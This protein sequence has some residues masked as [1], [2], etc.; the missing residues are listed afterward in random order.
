MAT[1]E[2][3]QSKLGQTLEKRRAERA[4]AIAPVQEKIDQI[5]KLIKEGDT[6]QAYRI[7]EE[8]PI[9]DQLALQLTPVVGDA[10]AVFE[11]KE[12]GTRASERFEQDDTLG[13]IGN[14]ALSGLSGLSLLPIVGPV[15]D[16]AGKAAKG[17]TRVSRV[18]D[19]MP[20]GGS[21]LPVL[22]FENK[23]DIDYIFTRDPEL[24]NSQGLISRQREVLQTFDPNEQF[25][26]EK[27]LKRMKQKAG[28]EADG[29]LRGLNV[30]TDEGKPHPNLIDNYIPM[31]GI[32][33]K[34]ITP[35]ELDAYLQSQQ[36][37]LLKV[38]KVDEYDMVDTG[39]LPDE[40][41]RV[42][43]VRDS[44][45][46]PITD[47]IHYRSYGDDII[48][49][50]GVVK[51]GTG[52]DVARIQSDMEEGY[53]TIASKKRMR[54]Q[55]GSPFELME[56]I[57]VDP[58]EIK[59][60]TE[61]V[62]SLSDEY[63]DL[64]KEYNT[65]RNK[66]TNELL[67]ADAPSRLSQKQLSEYGKSVRADDVAGDRVDDKM[68]DKLNEIDGI[69]K[70][71][72][73]KTTG[74]TTTFENLY[75]P[76]FDLDLTD[77]LPTNLQK[78]IARLKY[79]LGDRFPD[80][81]S[82]SGAKT[83]IKLG[84]KR[85][86]ADVFNPELYLAR[87]IDTA[88][89]DDYLKSQIDNINNQIERLNEYGALPRDPYATK[90]STK[91]FKFPLRSQINEAAQEGLPEI[92]WNPEETLSREGGTQ[93]QY[94]RGYY[95]DV[96]KEIKKV[97]NELDIPEAGVLS[98][99]DDVRAFRIGTGVEQDAR[100]YFGLEIMRDDI[101]L[102]DGQPLTIRDINDTNASINRAARGLDVEID[103]EQAEVDFLA[104]LRQSDPKLADIESFK[105]I[106]N[107]DTQLYKKV[108]DNLVPLEFYDGTP[109]TL[110]G[111]E[112]LV[113]QGEFSLQLQPVRDAIYQKG[114]GI[115]AFK[116][117][118]SVD[119][120]SLLNNL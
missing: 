7:F 110:K 39:S 119:I 101:Y 69:I 67:S 109:F 71:G 54:G 78:P 72:L 40:I 86:G 52:V 107:L 12:F 35:R 47:G 33:P 28:A 24:P 58:E 118:G 20:G 99:A 83:T 32:D 10:L 36:D 31:K 88:N 85:Y 2:K 104:R 87:G 89:A 16:V 106:K 25:V 60:I 90:T 77:D 79:Y 37:T 97:L 1:K 11:T 82:G 26:L 73:F 3:P 80:I 120:D 56:E 75:R 15:A 5:T 19:D 9:L 95:N 8:L 103:L 112:A 29:E 53:R 57:E 43:Q 49:F 6:R 114:K 63:N 44:K 59:K 115:Y 102:K 116:S 14:L 62:A 50:D 17:L 23:G 93:S 38:T 96:F 22:D 108:G 105:D 70:Q 42:Y 41:Q 91:S 74:E 4:A 94:L 46:S 113:K 100:N 111:G 21:S 61:S 98:K 68:A 64:A 55:K 81:F 84:R 48:A 92:R 117:G 34:K 51:D 76:N 30:I 65:I 45:I 66:T 18:A 13:G 27:L